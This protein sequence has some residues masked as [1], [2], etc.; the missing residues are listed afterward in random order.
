LIDSTDSIANK[1]FESPQKMKQ[2]LLN[3]SKMHNISYNNIL[4]LMKQRENISYILTEDKMKQYKIYKKE[5]EKPLKIIKAIK[6]END[7]SFKV[8]EVWDISQTNAIPKENKKLSKEY[9]ETMLK[10]ICSRREIIFED[11]NIMRNL[12]SIVMSIRDNTRPANLTKYNVDEYASQ[13]QAEID[14]T[15]YTVAQ[16]L[17]INTRNYNLNNICKWGIDKD[18]GELKKSLKYIQMFTNYF[19]KDFSKQEKLYK[20]ENEKQEDEELE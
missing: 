2:F 3:L 10:G 20:I 17:N 19:I 13:T 9:I 18:I 15:I 5:G 6:E 4:L 16:K 7:V 11:D 14:A 8:E 1:L 12:E